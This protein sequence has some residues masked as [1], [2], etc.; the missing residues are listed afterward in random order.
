ML[1]YLD[2]L[3]IAAVTMQII[4][5]YTPV[6]CVSRFLMGIYCGFTLGLV[7]SYTMSISPSFKSGIIGSF[8]QIAMVL[9]M[10]F[11]YYMGNVLDTDSFES[12]TSVR[13]LVGLPLV[14]TVVHLITLFL[15]PFDNIERHIFKRDN[16]TVRKYMKMVYGPK[17][18]AFE[19]EIR[20]HKIIP[21][22]IEVEPTG[23][24]EEL[25]EPKCKKLNSTIMAVMLAVA[26]QGT[27]ITAIQ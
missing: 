3:A 8:S 4:T 19:E 24:E 22:E 2:F 26:A 5:I 20:L 11:A 6:L 21:V 25:P 17:W 12:S 10:A 13:I 15:F 23:E 14:C 16:M 9:G 1:R 27:G 18:K 7:P